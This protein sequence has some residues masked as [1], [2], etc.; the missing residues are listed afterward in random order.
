MHVDVNGTRLWFDVDGPSH[1]PNGDHMREKFSVLSEFI[2]AKVASWHNSL[3][4]PTGT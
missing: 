3:K 4:P 2:T 1:V